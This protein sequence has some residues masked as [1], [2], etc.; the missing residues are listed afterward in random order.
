M[1]VECRRRLPGL[2]AWMESCYSCH[3]LLHLGK[4]VIHSCCGVQQGHPLGPLGFSLTLHSIVERIMGGIHSYCVGDSGR[5][6]RGHYHHHSMHWEGN[7]TESDP[8]GLLHLPK[9]P[10]PPS[11]DCSVE[12]QCMPMAASP[13]HSSPLCGRSSL[14][15]YACC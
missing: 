5:I 13:P 4:D 8:P 2:S 9:A 1:F 12:G 3:P 11:G 6:G 7:G 15:Y 14:N 10:F